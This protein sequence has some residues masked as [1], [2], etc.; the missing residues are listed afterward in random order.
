MRICLVTNEKLGE[1]IRLEKMARTL[2]RSGHELALVCWLDKR[3]LPIK[4]C[5][6]IPVYGIFRPKSRLINKLLTQVYKL[7][8]IDIWA[9][10]FILKAIDRFCPHVVLVRDFDLV[11]TM[12]V[13][14]KLRRFKVI[15]DVN[16]LVS[17]RIVSSSKVPQ[18]DWVQFRNKLNAPLV[19][20]NRIRHL[21]SR[22]FHAVDRI[23]IPND[24][25]KEK[26][27]AM[28]VPG[29]KLVVL[30]NY[31]DLEWHETKSRAPAVLRKYK[32]QFIISYVGAF[33]PR[34]GVDVLIRAMPMVL[35]TIPEAK[36]VLVG[37]VRDIEANLKLSLEN[38]AREMGLSDYI[39]FTGTVP[40]ELVL[41]YV[42]A[43]DIGVIP[44][45]DTIHTNNAVGHK[46]FMYMAAAKPL[47]V[48][49]LH[50]QAEV[51]HKVGCG[52]LIPPDDPQHLA[53]AI[54]KLYHDPQ[55][56]HMLGEKGKTAV[57]QGYNWDVGSR[58]FMRMVDKLAMEIRNET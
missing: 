5:E 10:P 49:N 13:A 38:L 3:K 48:T 9:L 32:D 25:Y 41:S 19:G 39:E 43:T 8:Y 11:G 12:L 28:G 37:P 21:E 35:D 44:F 4:F 24:H 17:Y 51:V 16:D 15:Y 58:E 53:E 29:E 22:Y 34:R 23:S 36:L 50:G 31:E 52:L 1:S 18:G 30:P 26:M 6:T 33:Y 40:T 14:K 55:L 45:R 47:I 27:L 57:Q 46:V 2:L 20:V 42:D 56:R 54:V 7:F